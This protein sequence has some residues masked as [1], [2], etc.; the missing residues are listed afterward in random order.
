MSGVLNKIGTRSGRI[1]AGQ[2]RE[3]ASGGGGI[4]THT[5]VADG[6]L[7]NG[8]RVVLQA[9]GKVKVVGLAGGGGLSTITN[10]GQK[11]SIGFRVGN[12]SSKPPGPSI[13]YDP[14]DVNKFAI[15]YIN[16]SNY[17]CMIIGSISGTTITIGSELVMSSLYT[18]CWPSFQW[19]PRQ[20]NLIIATYCTT[21]GTVAQNG[22]RV[23][24]GIV[25]GN[26]ITFGFDDQVLASASGLNNGRMHLDC[27]VSTSDSIIPALSYV[28]CMMTYDGMSGIGAL[29]QISG[30]VNAAVTSG[31]HGT[32]ISVHPTE[33]NSAYTTFSQ[34]WNRF[35][36]NNEAKVAIFY[37]DPASWHLYPAIEIQTLSNPSGVPTITQGTKYVVESNNSGRNK[38]LEWRKDV[39]DS[40]ILSWRC[41]ISGWFHPVMAVGTVSGTAV[42]FGPKFQMST[43]YFMERWDIIVSSNVPYDVG[44]GGTTFYAVGAGAPTGGKLYGRVMTIT[45]NMGSLTISGGNITTLM[46]P[47]YT[48][49][50]QQ[51]GGNNVGYNFHATSDGYNRILYQS[52]EY[53]HTAGGSSGYQRLST[54]DIAT[55]GTSNLTAGNY[56]GI[57]DGAY[58]SG[59]TATIQLSSPSIDDSQTGLTP[60]STYYIQTDGTLSTVA[61]SPSVLAGIAI[62]ATQ[63]LIKG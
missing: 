55:S 15:M 33:W 48:S 50:S 10:D 23:T 51:T 21:G 29:Y 18:Q 19:H 41:V 9:D 31:T 49:S 37:E 32:A 35:D 42:T 54:A 61:G 39:A 24:A 1:W 45:N 47:I 57:S 40:L 20:A 25:S 28:A 46:D 53:G 11:T 12:E 63:L 7:S 8:D 43:V 44:I 60:G 16:N 56:L 22:W 4:S 2:S 52:A 3:E 5:A 14:N 27:K 58:G 30:F 59:V 13:E 36:P 38:Q 6:A 34:P 17:T 62:S 26:S